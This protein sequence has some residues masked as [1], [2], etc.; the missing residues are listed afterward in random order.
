M[1]ETRQRIAE[2][3]RQYGFKLEKEMVGLLKLKKHFFDGIEQHSESLSAFDSTQTLVSFALQS[4]SPELNAEISALEQT[5]QRE[6]TIDKDLSS[7]L[8]HS[9]DNFSKFLVLCKY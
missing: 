8:K 6:C 1:E 4:I 5:I 3:K 7:D 9:I 2:V